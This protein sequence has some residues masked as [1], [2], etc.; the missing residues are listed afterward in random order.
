MQITDATQMITTANKMAPP[1]LTP[2]I[3][4]T[5]RASVEE[6]TVQ[7]MQAAVNIATQILR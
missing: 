1:E 6:G 5:S 2:A 7:M 3:R 4:S